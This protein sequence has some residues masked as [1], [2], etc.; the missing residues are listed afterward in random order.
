[1]RAGCKLRPGGATR[2]AAAMVAA[3]SVAGCGS[4]A[5]PEPAARVFLSNWS[6]GHLTTAG[7]ATNASP[8]T[9]AS[10]LRA[11]DAGLNATALSFRVVGVE[12]SG[13][14]ARVRFDAR[15]RLGGLGGWSY[16]G[17]LEMVHS[18]G[19]WL[20]E[21]KPQDLNPALGTY[22]QLIAVRVLPPRAPLLDRNGVAL[23]KPTPVVTVGV[24]PALLKPRARVIATL[25]STLHI[26]AA[27]LTKA[28]VREP[29]EDFLP[30][31]TLRRSAYKQVRAVIH[32]L[33]G[34]HFQTGTLP[35]GPTPGFGRAVLGEV[36]PATATAIRSAGPLALPSDDIGL[37]GLQ[38]VY[39]RRLAGTPGGRVEVVRGNGTVVS[40]LATFGAKAG[41]PVK[42]TLS[43]SLQSAA[44]K[45]LPQTSRPS[46]LVAVQAST[47][48]IL[49]VANRP[50]DST[51]DL[52]LDGSYPPGSTFKVITTAALL[53]RGFNPSSSVTCPPS[54]TVDGKRFTNYA[55]ESAPGASFVRDF[56]MS[57]N[58]A[59]ISLADRLHQNDLTVQARSFGFGSAWNM[60]LAYY[61]GQA[62]PPTSPTEKAADMIGQGRILASPL[63]M[64]LVAAAVQS[65]TW[66]PPSLLLSPSLT[67][68]TAPRT[69][70]ASTASELRTLMRA[71]VT[72]GTGT[73]ANVSGPPVYGK[74]GTAEF[75]SGN[76]PPTD[77]WFIGFRGD[78][79]FAVVV[80]GGGVGGT[81]AA[82]IA[83]KFLRDGG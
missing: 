46:A 31:I 54:I 19:R 60:P 53:A 1:M 6:A 27:A 9:V 75:G 64:A 24:V 76:P 35:L 30:V 33:A 21:W 66:H 14:R 45:A 36:G 50:A 74:T 59:F 83:A 16:R 39:Q 29:P 28:V 81:V 42:T 79:A 67:Q 63:T 8:S 62:P 57:C 47:G 23:Q 56:A 44:E 58:D 13:S 49:A 73:A 37:N 78:V 71:V 5:S 20:V 40:T 77:A 68:R 48:Q 70:P 69:I 10:A 12:Q 72:S 32:P 7:R 25:A 55:G 52:G 65:G 22:N 15:V 26:D 3:V 38:F 34:V 11:F 41:T 2:L 51:N 43:L 82:P 18:S 61:S 4:G 17:R 80:Q